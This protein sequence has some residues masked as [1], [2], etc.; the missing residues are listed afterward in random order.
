MS[1]LD[2]LNML[3][4]S[5]FGARTGRDEPNARATL[6]DAAEAVA[7]LKRADLQLA[8][9][10]RRTLEAIAS[11]EQR[12]IQAVRRG[13]D[14]EAHRLLQQ[15]SRLETECRNLESQ[16]D[17]NADELGQMRGALQSVRHRVQSTGGAYAP[18]GPAPY[19]PSAA[20]YVPSAAPYAAPMRGHDQ[21]QERF[22]ELE[23]QLHDIEARLDADHYADTAYID[24]LIDPDQVRL[25]REIRQLET[26][27]ALENTH[28]AD[29]ALSRLRAAMNKKDN[30]Q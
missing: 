16:R 29:D 2:R 1:I 21:A 19:A 26:Q 7:A 25:D 9:A 30:D 6:R 13:D 18:P 12:A 28:S 17:R 22:A 24:P 8:D 3:V 27:Q 10:E 14:D 4:R 23:D 20:P 15:K 5:E 11:L